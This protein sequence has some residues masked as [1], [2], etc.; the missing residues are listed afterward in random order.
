MVTYIQNSV[1]T[2]LPNPRSPLP[3]HFLPSLSSSISPNHNPSFLNLSLFH[4]SPLPSLHP[5]PADKHHT[6]KHDTQGR[7]LEFTDTRGLSTFQRLRFVAESGNK[8]VTSQVQCKSKILSWLKPR[9]LLLLKRSLFYPR[10]VG[11]NS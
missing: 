5:R 7:G 1:S 6:I 11:H 8:I 3:Y 9:I 10:V 4:T 2:S